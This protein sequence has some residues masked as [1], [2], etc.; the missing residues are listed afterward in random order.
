M[1][2]NIDVRS[3]YTQRASSEVLGLLSSIITV[4]TEQ[5]SP[6]AD[7][8]GVYTGSEIIML[9][10]SSELSNMLTISLREFSLRWDF[11]MKSSNIIPVV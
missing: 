7:S 2:P 5:V 1:Q 10:L 4:S 9:S 6:V 3:F 8:D 11:G